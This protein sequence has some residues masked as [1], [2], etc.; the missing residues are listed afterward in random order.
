MSIT[1]S[2]HTDVA[3]PTRT[4]STFRYA[5]IGF[6][7]TLSVSIGALLGG[8]SFETHLPGAWFFGMPGGHL[9]ALGSS[10]QQ[11][12]VYSMIAVYGG[13]ILLFR[14]WWGLI[15]LVR[16][17]QGFPI[18]KVVLVICIWAL[19]LLV[20][21]PLFSRDV[22]SYAGQ[23]ELV[24]HN[25]NPYAY[26][27]SVL[28]TTSFSTLPDPFWGNAASPYGPTFL[29][30][31]GAL[32]TAS[33]HGILADIVLLR[34]LEV[35]G[36]ALV[37]AA[38][39]TLARAL[40]RDPAEALLLG[41]GSPLIL[42]TLVAGAHNDA[43]MLGLLLAG[44]AVA[45][46]VG[47]VPGIIICALAAGVKSPAALGVVFLG[48]LWAGHG[49][50]IKSRIAHTALAGVIGLAT[51][52]L[53]TLA[54]GLGW[55]W[56]KTSTTANAAFTGVTPVSTM[57]HLV[58]LISGVLQIHLSVGGL[59]TVFSIVGL[60]CAAYLGYR[61]LLRSPD[62]G[63]QRNLGLTLLAL[64]LLGPVVWGWYVTWGIVVLAPAATGALRKF[65]MFLSAYWTFVGAAALTAVFGSLFHSG[66][67]ADLIF[68]FSML[69]LGIMP[70]G[71][72]RKTSPQIVVTSPE[73]STVPAATSTREP[74]RL[75]GG[76]P[77]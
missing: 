75:I 31:D 74:A 61:F 55:G 37:I 63:L 57:A 60:L 32:D 5:L 49:A 16:A 20:A 25:I 40:K 26:G 66:I 65:S 22:Y 64:A 47:T 50:S 33:G 7:G 18:K 43:L 45:K 19:P 15:R 29:S 41:A 39:P 77:A 24:S 28:G 38:T 48:W 1:L 35:A 69:A 76:S 62:S 70:L 2:E 13:L 52:E 46:R 34:L 68:M 71:L 30:I 17:H 12:P 11:P 44:L 54:S 10:A 42:A 56:V 58:A 59:H 72:F 6:L 4:P 21:P 67:L 3:A 51:L 36:I 73:P 14:A 23:G 27:P 53:V 8:S 9:G